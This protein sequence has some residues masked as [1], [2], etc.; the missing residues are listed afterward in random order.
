M[1]FVKWLED[2][3]AVFLELLLED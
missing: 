1:Y 2:C 3:K